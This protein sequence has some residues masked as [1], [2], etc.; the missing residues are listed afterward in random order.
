MKSHYGLVD[1]RIEKWI[2]ADGAV[3]LYAFFFFA[4]QDEKERDKE[5]R[6]DDEMM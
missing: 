4:F 2:E 3:L 5:K 6:W 1:H